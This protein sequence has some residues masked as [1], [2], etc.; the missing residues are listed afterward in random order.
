MP[1]PWVIPGRQRVVR[2][3]P[4][5]PGRESKHGEDCPL[6]AADRV[7]GGKSLADTREKFLVDLASRL[8][9][10]L[11]F[12]GCRIEAGRSDRLVCEFG[13]IRFAAG[14][15]RSP[16]YTVLAHRAKSLFGLQ[17]IVR[18]QID[19]RGLQQWGDSSLAA[20]E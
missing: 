12:V 16:D 11:G 14:F 6:L 2:S 8:H 10:Q 13:S 19:V 20:F 5:T 17:L 4:S 18:V 7:H 3:A 1:Y 9:N 15:Q